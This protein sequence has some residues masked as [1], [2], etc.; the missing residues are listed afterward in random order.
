[1]VHAH[2]HR[3]HHAALL[4]R[5]LEERD[6]KN[7]A[8]TIVYVTA[9]PTFDGPI[10]GYVTGVDPAETATRPNQGVGAPLGHTRPTTT[11][12]VTTTAQPKPK[13]TKETKPTITEAEPT[14]TQRTTKATKAIT[15]DNTED[16][17]TTPTT[18]STAT[19]SSTSSLTIPGLDTTTTTTTHGSSS[20]EKSASPS[21]SP[22]AAG[23]SSG[24]TG[25][26]KAGIAIGV[27]L[28][29]GLIAGFIFFVMRKR[30]QGQQMA[31]A[32]AIKEKSHEADNMLPPGPP[33]KPQPMT[34]AEPPQL[35]VRPVTQFA[36][37]LTPMGTLAAGGAGAGATLGVAAAGSRNLTGNASPPH[38]PQSSVS[39][40]DPFG[41]PVN[42]FGNQ[43]EAPSPVAATGPPSPSAIPLPQSPLSPTVPAP[44]D[45]GVESALG[46]A[47]TGAAVAGGVAAVAAVAAA[48]L[49]DK[50]LPGRPDSSSSQASSVP[51]GSAPSPVSAVSADPASIATAT[52]VA[53]V[54]AFGPGGATGPPPPGPSNVHRVQMDFQPSMEDELEL[55]AGQLV[56]L[57]H[58]YDDGWALCVRLD[59]SQQGVVPRS[60]LS[61]R[62]VKPRARPPPGAGPGPGPRG[63]PRPPMMGPNGPWAPPPGPPGP[64]GPVGP[65]G[66]PPPGF[67]PHDPRPRSPSAPRPMSP[68][69][70]PH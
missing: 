25:G 15:T 27:I 6:P 60:C 61:A 52:A 66:P 24:L 40:T 8:V 32:E 59:R 33:P 7:E 62:P 21:A 69:Q 2:A 44:S 34:P 1:M 42:P 67:Y 30:K 54:P 11:E 57:L 46:A 55:R 19:S 49:S 35:N 51:E 56:R 50:D 12:E 68:A 28:G 10:G 3:D 16:I 43:A 9:A 20:L 37:D 5:S 29:L 63:P 26:A 4:E 58:E 23:S 47:A 45:A 13:T 64:A 70:H 48:K 22:V 41:D 38:T 36:P 31:E 14:T 17:I 65:M 18:F 53:A 39:K